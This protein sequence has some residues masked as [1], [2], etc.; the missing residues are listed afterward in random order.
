MSDEEMTRD[1]ILAAYRGRRSQKKGKESEGLAEMLLRLKGVEMVEKIATPFVITDTRRDRY[2]TWYRI[3]WEQKVSGDRRGILRGGRRV[4]AE[5][6]A[7][8]HNLQWSNFEDHQVEALNR[9]HE[10]GGLSLVVYIHPTINVV[11]EWPIPG[12]G[13][14]VGISPEEA[15]L[16]EW[17]GS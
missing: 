11:M 2:G 1:E 5:V 9:N 14:G 4:L 7:R 3:V 13:P 10:L 15:E 16:Y 12:F 8:K 6:K 17:S